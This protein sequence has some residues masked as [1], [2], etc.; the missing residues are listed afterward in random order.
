MSKF[1]DQEIRKYSLLL[2]RVFATWLKQGLDKPLELHQMKH[3]RELQELDRYI[4]NQNGVLS[5]G[6]DFSRSSRL[7]E[8]VR[9]QGGE[10]YVKA[11]CKGAQG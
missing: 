9:Y 11:Q 5:S 4:E 7:I 6:R 8:L 3:Q 1:V 2:P 10:V